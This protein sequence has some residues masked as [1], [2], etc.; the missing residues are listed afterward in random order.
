MKNGDQ[1]KLYPRN[2]KEN[3]ILLEYVTAQPVNRLHSFRGVT[4]VWIIGHL[5]L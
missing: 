4:N 1:N 3:H 2:E 5:E